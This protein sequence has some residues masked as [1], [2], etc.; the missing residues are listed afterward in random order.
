MTTPTRETIEGWSPT[1]GT[2]ADCR[3]TTRVKRAGALQE[4]ICLWCA[5]AHDLAGR[6]HAELLA[7]SYLEVGM[8]PIDGLWRLDER[9]RPPLR[10]ISL[11]SSVSAGVLAKVMALWKHDRMRRSGLP[12][13]VDGDR[14]V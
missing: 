3:E 6:Q 10:I 9:P 8:H 13:F 14:S 1:S 7:E 4:T 12:R 11:V 2:C 5:V